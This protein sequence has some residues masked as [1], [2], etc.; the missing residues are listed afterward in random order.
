MEISFYSKQFL[1]SYLRENEN[2]N[3]KLAILLA[4]EIYKVC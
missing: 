4:T 2:F 1:S 3:I